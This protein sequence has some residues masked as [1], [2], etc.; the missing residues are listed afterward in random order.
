[1][2]LRAAAS[3]GRATLRAVGRELSGAGL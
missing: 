3:D 1:M 2:A